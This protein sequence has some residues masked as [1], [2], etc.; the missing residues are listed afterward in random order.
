MYEFTEELYV[1][2]PFIRIYKTAKEALDDYD[3]ETA[4]SEDASEAIRVTMHLIME[5]VV[6][7]GADIRRNNLL[8]ADEVVVFVPDNR[9]TRGVR[10]V[11]LDER[12]IDGTNVLNLRKIDFCDPNYMP[13]YYIFLYFCGN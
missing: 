11:V 13:L 9:N 12:R 3:K 8:I 5:M 7:R 6:E 4:E 10:L 1:I 2:N